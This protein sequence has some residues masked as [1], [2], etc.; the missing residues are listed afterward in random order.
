MLLFNSDILYRLVAAIAAVAAYVFGTEDFEW[1]EC[2]AEANKLDAI[3]DL[4]LS[5][6]LQP[7]H[8]PVSPEDREV[9]Q[10][11]VVLHLTDH[12]S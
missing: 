8:C 5:D 4:E 9:F 6:D 7:V 11:L 10:Q 3:E 12:S 1:L 2:A